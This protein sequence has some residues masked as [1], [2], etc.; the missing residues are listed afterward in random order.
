MRLGWELQFRKTIDARETGHKYT[1]ASGTYELNESDAMTMPG[2]YKE[3][4]SD[5]AFLRVG[6]RQASKSYRSPFGAI[7][8]GRHKVPRG[9][10]VH[11]SW[12]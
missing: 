10:L 7:R 5:S 4:I 11:S 3:R 1:W 6:V 8:R 9:L 12:N 2:F